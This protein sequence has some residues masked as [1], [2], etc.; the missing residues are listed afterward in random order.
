MAIQRRTVLHSLIS[1]AALSGCRALPKSAENA[2]QDAELGDIEQGNGGRLG[3]CAL[4]LQ[5][6][7]APLLWRSGERFAMCSTFKLPLAAWVLQAADAGQLALGDTLSFSQADMVPNSPVTTSHLAEGKL[8]LLALAEAMQKT[9]DNLAANLVLK[10]LGG[11]EAFTRW[12]RLQGDLQSRLDRYE[13]Q[14]NLVF[15][16]DQRD[17][18]MPAA[19]AGLLTS[20]FSA[21]QFSTQTQSRLRD[22]MI[23]TRTGT[24]RLRAGFP[25]T[26]Q[27]GDKTGTALHPD[28][29]NKYNDVAVVW[30]GESPRL[31]IAAFYEADQYYTSMR[32][33]DQAVLA[34]VGRRVTAWAR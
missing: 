24:E 20:I 6:T 8:S 11:P 2:P 22:W 4:D 5:G 26:W 18:T 12:L 32:P 7:R 15:G 34:A 31:I 23:A 10:H 30:Q 19:M 16:M 33:Q 17:T 25:A 1:L 13:P 14:V 28:M 29:A 3:V 21:K 9:S 27:A